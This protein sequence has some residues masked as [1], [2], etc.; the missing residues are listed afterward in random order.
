VA[1]GLLLIAVVSSTLRLVTQRHRHPSKTSVYLLTSSVY[2]HSPTIVTIT[3]SLREHQAGL[4]SQG[5]PYWFPSDS[6]RV[7]PWCHAHASMME[8]YLYF[9]GTYAP[10]VCTLFSP[11]S[12]NSPLPLSTDTRVLDLD[13]FWFVEHRRLPSITCVDDRIRA[14]PWVIPC[15][16]FVGSY[17][18]F[19]VT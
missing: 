9:I 19:C 7:I 1:V 10:L 2:P 15:L 6:T 16:C 4:V 18:C 17:L 11:R 12:H 3:P 13:H 14:S 5:D 8:G